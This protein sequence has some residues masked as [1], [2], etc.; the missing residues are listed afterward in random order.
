M[1][2]TFS[3]TVFAWIF[4]RAEN[5]SHAFEY[6]A[7]ILS[8]SLFT[9]PQFEGRKQALAIVIAV[10][11]FIIIEWLGREEEYA[12]EKIGLKW[13]KP[14]RHTMYYCIVMAIYFFSG[15]EQE[16]IYFQF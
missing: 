1:L 8:T 10:V 16:F 5:I 11:V 13:R 9:I 14:L 15:K 6:I 12:I 2:L 7:E 3:L 4:F